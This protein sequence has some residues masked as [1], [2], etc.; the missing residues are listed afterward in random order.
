MRAIERLLGELRRGD[1]APRLTAD[2]LSGKP[3]EDYFG[4]QYSPDGKYLAFFKHER[5]S[6]GFTKLVI[7]SLSGDDTRE[8]LPKI[9]GPSRV[10][11]I[12]GAQAVA[13]QAND[14][15]GRPTL[16]KFDLRTGE[17]APIVTGTSAP[18]AFSPDG[19]TMYYAPYVQ[20][21]TGISRIM[22]HDMSTGRER[23]VYTAPPGRRVPV[24]S[25]TRDGKTIITMWSPVKGPARGPV[26]VIAVSVE[27][28]HHAASHREHPNGFHA[29]G[30]RALGFTPDQQAELIFGPAKAAP[31]TLTV[32]R[33]PLAGGEPTLVGPMAS[34][35]ALNGKHSAGPWLSPD[36]ARITYVH[37]GQKRELWKIDDPTI[38]SNISRR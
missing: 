10:T 31:H 18:V 20:N 34:V 8:F 37:G 24:H 21:D 26:G 14:R 13:I 25:V 28:R 30:A 35:I 5:V 2:R 11:W 36:G 33:A 38:R 9:M 15:D 1:R 6:V 3:G 4:P 22:A 32:W 17:A 23:V 12:P 19:S 27:N 16:F 29:Q 7:R